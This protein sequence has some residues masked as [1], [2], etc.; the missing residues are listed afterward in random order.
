MEAEITIS[1]KVSRNYVASS[2]LADVEAAVLELLKDREFGVTLYLQE[3][4][5]VRASVDGVDY[6]NVT[7]GPSGKLDGSGNLVPDADEVIT[8]G[9]VAVAEVS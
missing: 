7:L 3:V 1:V 4:Y 2:V 6:M 9:S 5:D 8:K